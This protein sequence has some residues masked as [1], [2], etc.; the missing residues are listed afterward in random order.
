[1]GV[2]GGCARAKINCP[3]SFST[4]YQAVRAQLLIREF[5]GIYA[6]TP[7][8]FSITFLAVMVTSLSTTFLAVLP[9]L[10]SHYLPGSNVA[11]R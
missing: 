2:V 9:H 1:M 5:L 3:L 10:L 4:T 11:P 6:P 7:T 8:T